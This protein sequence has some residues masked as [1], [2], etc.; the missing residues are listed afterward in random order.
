MDV[1]KLGALNRRANAEGVDEDVIEAAMD[2]DDPKSAL[3]A[4]LLRK[5][6]P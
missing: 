4:A 1:L 3:I 6:L 2:S 5:L